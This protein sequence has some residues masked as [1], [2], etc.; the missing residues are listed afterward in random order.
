[1]LNKQRTQH[2]IRCS[3]RSTGGSIYNLRAIRNTKLDI[4]LSQSDW[5]HYAYQGSSRFAAEGA[6]T[7]L[8]AL[9]SLHAEPFTLIARA[10]SGIQK[11]DD[12]IRYRVNMGAPGS[13]Q[14]GTINILLDLLGWKL[15]DFELA[16]QLPSNEQVN[17]LCSNKLDA[18]IITVGHPSSSVTQ[19]AQTCDIKLIPVEHPA[20][21][22]LLAKHRYY[23]EARIPGGL[24]PGNPND[25]PTFGVG[26]TVVS[27][28]NTSNKAIYT[29][30]KSVFD[31]LDEF[32][33][34]HPA[35]ANLQPAEMVQ[36][37]L[38]APLHPGAV[39]YY[40]EQGIACYDP[41]P[42]KYNL[43][44]GPNTFIPVNRPDR[45]ATKPADQPETELTP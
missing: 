45:T 26:A 23:R 31:N 35:L 33:S 36:D 21:D 20:I 43:R 1:M 28:S 39:Q 18:I 19:A 2:G 5:Q 34:L 12:I 7:R 11:L 15:A 38:S 17:A 14:R 6:N 13:G 41:V 4:G 29:L 25:I 10:D 37:S 27:S 9:F 42:S 16:A 8:R 32:K 44:C 40:Q 22:Q 24:Y 3:V 30:V